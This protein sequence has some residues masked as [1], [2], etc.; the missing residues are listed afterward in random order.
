M[1]GDLAQWTEAALAGPPVNNGDGT[2]TVVFRDT[3]AVP[4]ADRR[5]IRLRVSLE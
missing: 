3:V 1:S 2:E 5:F 4:E